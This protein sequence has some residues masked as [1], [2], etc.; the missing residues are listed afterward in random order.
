MIRPCDTEMVKCDTTSWKP[1]RQRIFSY[2]CN[3]S[4]TAYCLCN[5]THTTSFNTG[6]AGP[7]AFSFRF[8]V[9]LL[10]YMLPA[11]F[12]LEPGSLSYNTRIISQPFTSTLWPTR[13]LVNQVERILFPDSGSCKLDCLQRNGIIN[14]PLR[15]Q[16]MET[17]QYYSTMMM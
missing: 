6:G 11:C 16:L 1:T 17:S 10:R 14:T 5:S 4:Y 15:Q 9:T 8:N 12:L 7:I 3:S 13:C 2:I